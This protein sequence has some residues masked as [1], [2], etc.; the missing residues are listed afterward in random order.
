[1]TSRSPPALIQEQASLSFVERAENIVLLGPSGTGKT[2]LAIAF[3]LIAAQKSWKVRFTT[4]ADLVIAMEA[5]YRHGRMKEAMHRVIAAPKL[6][7]TDEI[8]YLPFGRESQSVLPSSCAPLR[9][10]LVDPHFEP[11]IRQLGRGVCGRRCAHSC[12]A[13]SDPAPRHRRSDCW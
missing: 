3:G 1:M 9:K 2:H 5:A 6:L 10:G 4:A 12:H 11:R 7:I 8:G 13:R